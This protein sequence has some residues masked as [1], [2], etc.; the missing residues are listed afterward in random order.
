MPC[1]RENAPAENLESGLIFEEIWVTRAVN[2]LQQAQKD[3][4][5]F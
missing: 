2:T 3:R 1:I 5:F 4:A